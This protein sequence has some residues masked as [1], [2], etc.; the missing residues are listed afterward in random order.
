MRLKS[1]FKSGWGLFCDSKR[2]KWQT[3]FRIELK[4]ELLTFFH[5]NRSEMLAIQWTDTTK[6][7]LY[8][9]AFTVKASLQSCYV[10]V[11]SH[12]KVL[13][14]RMVGDEMFS[15]FDRNGCL[16]FYGTVLN[17]SVT[18]IRVCLSGITDQLETSMVNEKF[19]CF[20]PM[21]ITSEFR[22]E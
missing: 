4:I 9:I 15:R 22:M 1:D 3:T 11:S 7:R 19:G 12:F 10:I 5:S 14:L 17:R 8:C 20:F 6:Y 21:V 13:F 2:I 18:A 16:S